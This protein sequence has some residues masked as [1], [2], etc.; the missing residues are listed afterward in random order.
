VKLG[1]AR[2]YSTNRF[3]APLCTANAAVINMLGLSGYSSSEGEDEAKV[4]I[5]N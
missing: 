3:D 4:T 5:R 1:A 2:A